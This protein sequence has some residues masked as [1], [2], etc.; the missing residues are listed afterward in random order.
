[1]I[2][3]FLLISP[4]TLLLLTGCWDITEPQKMYYVNGVGVDYIDNQYV[5]YLQFIN[6]SNVAKSEKTSPDATPSEIGHAKGKT[7]EEAIYKLYRSVDQEIFWGH[8][9]YLLLSEDALKSELANSVLDTFTRFRETRYQIY[10]HCTSDSIEEILLVTPILNKPLVNSKL[11]TPLNT[12]TLEAFTKPVNL[13]KLMIGLNEPSHEVALSLVSINKNWV[14]EKENPSTETAINGVCVISKDGFKGAITNNLVGG[15]RWMTGHKN[16]GNITFNIGDN[17][18]NY[19]TVDI[20]KLNLE[21]LPIVKGNQVTFEI[22]IDFEAIL[23][24]FKGNLN[25]NELEKGIAKKVKE[26]IKTT[27]EEG[28]NLDVDIYRLSEYLYRD[29]VKMWKKMEK[30]GKIPLTKDSIS[31]ITINVNKIL[32]GRK[33]FQDSVDE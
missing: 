31:K 11:S 26:E 1:M 29:N 10:V 19:I 17:E 24:G 7:I 14:S 28:L 16:L 2:R 30:N 12:N 9:T 20:E 32:S 3:I 13:R 8:M 22:D 15:N 23:N 5:I 25:V 33:V 21:V 18:S 6:F 27:Y 4:F